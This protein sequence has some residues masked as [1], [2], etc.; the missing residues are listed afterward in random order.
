[1]PEFALHWM[2]F[3]VPVPA[4]SPRFWKHFEFHLLWKSTEGRFHLSASFGNV[5][6]A[7]AERL[8]LTSNRPFCEVSWQVSSALKSPNSAS[9]VISNP[10]HMTDCATGGILSRCWVGEVGSPSRPS[11]RA[12]VSSAWR[13]A[14]ASGSCT[15]PPFGKPVKIPSRL[16]KDK[17]AFAPRDVRR[18]VACSCGALPSPSRR[19]STASRF[20]HILHRQKKS[21]LAL[22]VS[23]RLCY[24]VSVL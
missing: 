24:Y 22:E 2:T 11:G 10:L 4:S 23:K 16:A 3:S 1:M 6:G 19:E 15:R 13:R 18:D 21:F 9:S 20:R 8:S 12:A 14:A 5:A 7:S 17:P